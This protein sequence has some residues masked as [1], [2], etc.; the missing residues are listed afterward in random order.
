MFWRAGSTAHTNEGGRRKRA[1]R[2][3]SA[4]SIARDRVGVDPT[5]MPLPCRE[6][7]KKKRDAVIV[8]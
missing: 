5:P 4:S 8:K 7:E 6:G 1:M 3:L 2:L